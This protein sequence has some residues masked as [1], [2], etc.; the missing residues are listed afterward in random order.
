VDVLTFV[1]AMVE[2]VKAFRKAI[3]PQR[4]SMLVILE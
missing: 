2:L 1:H 4:G 3:M